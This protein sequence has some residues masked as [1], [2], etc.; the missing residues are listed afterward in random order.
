MPPHH[1]SMPISRNSSC[2]DPSKVG[3]SSH[4]PG[5][6]DAHYASRG[7]GAISCSIMPPL[8]FGA[9]AALSSAIF[10]LA[11]STVLPPATTRSLDALTSPPRTRS[12]VCATVKPC[13]SMIAS[14]QPSWQ[15][16][17]NS[18][19]R[20]RSG[21]GWRR[22]VSRWLAGPDATEGSTLPKPLKTLERVKGIEPSSS[23]WKAVA[24][25]LSYT[26]APGSS[27]QRSVIS[28]QA[29]SIV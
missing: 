21:L 29:T 16:A 1:A 12:T 22:R 19:A 20:R 15:V 28:G 25:P 26:R 6:T 3:S 17:S 18:R 2:S 13:A 23:A 10:S 9:L 24:L 11:T 5:Q 8:L 7:T 27:H 14:V 4:T